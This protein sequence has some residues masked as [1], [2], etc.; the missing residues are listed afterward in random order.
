MAS[1]GEISLDGKD[2]IAIRPN[3]RPVNMMFQSY[4]L[5][6]HLNVFNNVAYGLRMDRVRGPE[7]E[8]WLAVRPEK[9]TLSAQRPTSTSDNAVE[10]EVVDISYSGHYLS[11]RLRAPE[12]DALI[13]AKVGATDPVVVGIERGQAL[14]CLWPPSASRILSRESQSEV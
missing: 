4:A 13:L 12:A 9:L 6:L 10:G 8:V 11:I 2:Q 14:W 5:F 1:A 7:P 3:R